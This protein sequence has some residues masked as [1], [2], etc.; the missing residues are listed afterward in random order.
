MKKQYKVG[1][2]YRPSVEVIKLKKG[3]PSVLAIGGR[4]YILRSED[5]KNETQGN[6]E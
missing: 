5:Q 4:R 1:D 6:G 2:K 3:V